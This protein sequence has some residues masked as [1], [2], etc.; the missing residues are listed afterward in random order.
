MRFSTVLCLNSQKTRDGDL[1]YVKDRKCTSVG[2]NRIS[3]SDTVERAL[4]SKV[5]SSLVQT[6]ES[7]PDYSH[8]FASFLTLSHNSSLSDVVASNVV[9]RRPDQFDECVVFASDGTS[10]VCETLSSSLSD[11]ELA[12]TMSSLSDVSVMIFKWHR[13]SFTISFGA[14]LNTT[15]IPALL[16]ASHRYVYVYVSESSST[17]TVLDCLGEIE[18]VHQLMSALYTSG[19]GTTPAISPLPARRGAPA[20]L[21]QALH[22]YVR[23]EAHY[24]DLLDKL[25]PQH[26]RLAPSP[27]GGER[28]TTTIS[29]LQKENDAL[30][31]ELDHYRLFVRE[32]ADRNAAQ[33]LQ[34]ASPSGPESAEVE[35]LR[36]SLQKALQEK[37]FAEEKVRVLELRKQLSQ[38]RTQSPSRELSGPA[39]VQVELQLAQRENVSLVSEFLRKEKEWQRKLQEATAEIEKQKKVRQ[40]MEATLTLQS[41]TIEQAK[42]VI[43]LSQQQHRREAETVMQKTCEPCRILRPLVPSPHPWERRTTS[44]PVH[45]RPCHALT[46]AL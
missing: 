36:Q 13:K 2:S 21:E 5:A 46:G 44:S 42:R 27:S 37:Q 35:R 12:S 24:S 11:G 22:A 32:N 38:S 15:H 18:S 16:L 30:K 1:F 8:S 4:P 10:L 7:S 41:K 40:E 45:E 39:S 17:R 9:Q 14:L 25:S 3:V 34:H 19:G 43:L 26:G 29:E 6:I 28:E 31:V 23:S 20:S 33:R